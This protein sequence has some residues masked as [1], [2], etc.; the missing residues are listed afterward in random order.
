MLGRM[1]EQRILDLY[2]RNS[3]TPL[4]AAGDQVM[5]KPFEVANPTRSYL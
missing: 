4:L 3:T 5:A 1:V 2:G